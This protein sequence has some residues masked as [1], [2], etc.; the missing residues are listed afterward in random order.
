MDKF[1]AAA[2]PNLMAG[3]FG[4]FGVYLGAR[5]SSSRARRTTAIRFELERVERQLDELYGPLL[6]LD[7]TGA[8]LWALFCRRSGYEAGKGTLTAEQ[9]VEWLHW[10]EVVLHPVNRQMVALIQSHASLVDDQAD[11][12]LFVRLMENCA[13]YEA[14]IR[15]PDVDPGDSVW[16]ST[17][18]PEEVSHHLVE[19]SRQLRIRQEALLAALKGGSGQARGLPAD[20]H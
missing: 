9:R 5:L 13:E 11:M 1:W 2:L 10:L 6:A 12:D 7:K 20:P 18:F 14:L 3:G 16:A 17:V 4:L 19:K 15:K 8:G